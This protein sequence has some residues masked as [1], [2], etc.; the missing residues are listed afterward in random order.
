MKPVRDLQDFVDPRERMESMVTHFQH[1]R[2]WRVDWTR[3]PW[4]HDDMIV[5]DF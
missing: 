1:P 4:E 3:Q 2:D 5:Q